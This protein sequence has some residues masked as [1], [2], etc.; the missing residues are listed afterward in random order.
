MLLRRSFFYWLTAWV[1]SAVLA[2]VAHST[3]LV[4]VPDT[5]AERTRACAA[6]HGAQGEGTAN[7]Y[8]PR[9]AGQ[10]A[11]YLFEQLVQFREGH[12]TYRPMNY[13]VTYLSDD[14]LRKMADYFS[15]QRPP[16]GLVHAEASIKAPSDAAATPS[17]AHAS[18]Q[19]NTASTTDKL[20][21]KYAEQL[22]FLGD[23]K[24]NIPACIACHG[25]ALTGMQAGIAQPAIPG[26]VGL[27]SDYIRAQ[28]GAWRAGQRHGNPPD[29]MHSI[30][31]A[32]N[33]QDIR[34]VARWIAQQPV[35]ASLTPA[36]ARPLPLQCGTPRKSTEHSTH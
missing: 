9:L 15:A 18:I 1:S 14:Y 16:K 19:G 11:D 30:T 24:K 5:M 20:D 25:A 28:L 35:P 33:E 27:G 2:S 7:A 3:P 36:P 12:R 17:V 4:G 29:C 21:A 8:F 23:T 10:P 22:V 31:T 6:C 32:L 34:A 26:L 13:L